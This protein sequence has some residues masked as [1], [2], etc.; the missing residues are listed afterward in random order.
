MRI[1]HTIRSVNR[2]GGGPIE[3]VIQSSIVLSQL[4]HQVEIISLDSADD[5]CLKNVPL[6]THA[7]GA[8]KQTSYGY[9]ARFVP[10]LRQNAANYDLVLV[11]GIWQY[12]SFGVW[13][14]LKDL[15]IPYFVF[16]HGMLDPW[17][18][19]TYPLKHLK[20]WLY[21]F[22][23]EY[24]VLRDAKAVLFTCEQEKILARQ[25]FWLYKCHEAV[26]NF[27]TAAPP[28]N[29]AWYCQIFYQYF[30]H[31]YDKRLLL[32][33]S[34][35]HP[36]KGCDLLIEA[37]AE[38]ADTDESLHLV[39][40]GPDQIGWQ[41]QLQSLAEKLG[42]ADRITWTGML[43]GNLK[44]GALYAAEALI[45]PSHQENFGIAVAEALACGVPVLISN[46]VNIWQEIV[47]DGAGLVANDD[48][49]GTVALLLKW[50]AMPLIERENMRDRARKSFER[51]FEIHQAVNSL[52]KVLKGDRSTD[53][54]STYSCRNS[55]SSS[56]P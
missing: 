12:S 56:S 14:A 45:L 36:K 1:L 5:P 13:L 42:I 19:H 35:L 41:I 6:T 24:R 40:A 49:A 38:I 54:N 33:L 11:H 22:W 43:T 21:W 48:R 16:V 4:G 34:R 53:M 29:L 15:N 47:A 32:F 25:S 27:G 2:V 18:K 20:K 46:R 26:V 23:A 55:I 10:W 8:D 52:L 28:E 3:A 7:L 44:W 30:P 37:F 39:M 50:L 31:L 51:R 9:S 17:F